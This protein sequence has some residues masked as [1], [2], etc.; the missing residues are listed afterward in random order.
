[1]RWGHD[2]FISN[3]KRK[4]VILTLLLVLPSLKL[5][6]VGKGSLQLYA[7]SQAAKFSFGGGPEFVVYCFFMVDLCCLDHLVS[8]S[9]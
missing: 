5:I 6:K 4:Y 3:N 1:M 7:I 2:I 9:A 8:K